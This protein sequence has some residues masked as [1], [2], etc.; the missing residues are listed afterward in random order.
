MVPDLLLLDIDLPDGSGWEVARELRA[1][2]RAL[3]PI[4][5]VSALHPNERLVHELGCMGFLE[6]PFP[7]E[8]LIRK[9]QGLLHPEKQS[10]E[11]TARTYVEG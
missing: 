10:D 6:K 8:A 11:E 9:V 5:V 2:S 1:R 4:V 3:V 7:M